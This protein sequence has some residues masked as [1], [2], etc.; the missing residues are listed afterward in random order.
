MAALA[1]IA[2]S[3]E[4]TAEKVLKGLTGLSPLVARRSPVHE[5]PSSTPEPTPTVSRPRTSSPVHPD[6]DER[7]A[8]TLVAVIR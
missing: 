6:G 4:N 3:V 5:P 8:P 7:P 1:A 2:D